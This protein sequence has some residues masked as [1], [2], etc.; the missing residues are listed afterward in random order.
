MTS[1]ARRSRGAPRRTARPEPTTSRTPLL[2]VGA[3]IAVVII[4][5]I[6]ALAI[7]GGGSGLAEPATTPID[8]QGQ[9]LPDL[10][11]S[12]ADPAAGQPIPALTGTDLDGQPITIGPEDGP[13]AIVILA[14]WCPHCQAEVPLLVDY[15]SSTGMP[16]G[17]Q[18]VALSTSINRAQPNYPPSAWLER[19]GWTA[20]TL[21]DDANSSALKALGMSSFPGFVFVDASGAVVSRTTGEIPMS[22]FDQAVNALAP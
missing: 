4:A 10:P 18:L 3:V 11:A 15:L 19:E 1:K 5:A 8:V 22:S 2:I 17:V 14:H 12:G 9:A 6:V 20:P 7:G 13:M 21:I 16:D